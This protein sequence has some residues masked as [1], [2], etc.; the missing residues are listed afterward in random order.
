MR[1][2]GELTGRKADVV[3]GQLGDP[4]VELE[5]QGERLTNATGGTEDG[6]LGRLQGNGSAVVM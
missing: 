6:D 5:Q 3:E 1:S 2:D 4:G